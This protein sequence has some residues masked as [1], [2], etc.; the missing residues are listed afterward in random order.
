MPKKSIVSNNTNVM[1]DFIGGNLKYLRS[2][3]GY[4]QDYVANYLSVTRTTYTKW[5]TGVSQ[6]EYGMLLQL[7]KLYNTDFNELLCYDIV[8]KELSKDT[9]EGKQK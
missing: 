6:I 5:E 2:R 9:K 4:T 8:I 1:K 7:A 3:F